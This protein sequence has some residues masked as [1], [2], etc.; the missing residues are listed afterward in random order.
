M[1][2]TKYGDL[3]RLMTKVVAFRST[4]KSS[5]GILCSVI[6]SARQRSLSGLCTNWSKV[7]CT[8]ASSNL[9]RSSQFTGPMSS[10]KTPANDGEDTDGGRARKRLR[11]GSS[12]AVKYSADGDVTI[13]SGVFWDIENI[14]VKI[15]HA[16]RKIPEI[17][18][19]LTNFVTKINHFDEDPPSAKTIDKFIAVARQRGENAMATTAE[20]VKQHLIHNQVTELHE[21]T[22]IKD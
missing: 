12:S 21:H 16:E 9:R 20:P 22:D 14:P 13:K 11:R 4:E 3:N 6:F 15:C 2:R 7:C 1:W 19:A 17:K 8:F 18:Q 10:V 5:P